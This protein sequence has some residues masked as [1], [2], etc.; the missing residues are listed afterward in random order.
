MLPQTPPSD[1]SLLALMDRPL[2]CPNGHPRPHGQGGPCPLCGSPPR[3]EEPTHARTAV[4]AGPEGGSTTV[5]TS[6]SRGLDLPGYEMLG[7]L[8]RGG[9]GTVHQ[10]RHLESQRLVAVKVLHEGLSDD[11]EHRARFRAEARALLR[12]EHPGIVRCLEAGEQAG[13]PY[14]VLELMTGGSLQERLA[15]R[16]FSPREAA[17]LVA[18]LALAVQAA[19]AAGIIHRDLKPGNVLMDGE[20][21][22]KVSDFGLAKH[23]EGS[24]LHTM[25]GAIM[26]TPAYMA[27]EQAAGRMSLIGPATDVYA[28]GAILYTLL[29]GQAPFSGESK[30]HLLERVRTE[31]PAPPTRLRP[32]VPRDLETICLK[33]LHKAPEGRYASAQA[34][35]DDL[36]RWLENRPILARRVGLAE[37]AAKWRQR[38]PV[39]A[40]LLVVASLASLAGGLGALWYWNAYLRVTVRHYRGFTL[41]KDGPVGIQALTAAEARGLSRS[42]RLSTR[43]GRA[44][45][46]ESV[47]ALGEL[48]EAS[49]GPLLHRAQGEENYP[50]R[51]RPCQY[52]YRRGPGGDLT[53]E[54]ARDQRGNVLW[55]LQ[56]TTPETA[57]YVNAR[58][59]ATARTGSGAAFVRFVWGQSG[60]ADEVHYLGHG[61]RPHPNDSGIYGLRYTRDE[62]GRVA[63]VVNLGRDGRPALD[64]D[65]LS[66]GEERE[67][68]GRGRLVRDW[69]LDRE[70]RRSRGANWVCG[71]EYK[72][73]EAGNCV[74]RRYFDE[75]GRPCLHRDG[76]HGWRSTYDERGYALSRSYFGLDGKPAVISQGMARVD[77]EPDAEGNVLVTRYFGADGAPCLHRDG[78]HLLRRKFDERGVL[79]EGAYYGV[80]GEPVIARGQ[81]RWV[82]TV[83]D[84]GRE[85]ETRYYGPDGNPALH[86]D[87]NHVVRRKYDDRGNVTEFSFFGVNQRPIL[88]KGGFAVRRIRYDEE[89]RQVEERCFGRDGEPC[90]HKEGYHGYTAK[91]DERGYRSERSYFGVDD[92]RVYHKAGVA[93]ARF[94]HD[95]QGREIEARYFGANNEPCLH[96]EGNH[97]IR[98]RYDGRGNLIQQEFLGLKDELVYVPAKGFARSL[99]EYDA[100]GLQRRQ[101]L[102]GPDG[103]PCLH[104]DGNAGVVH[105][106]N[107][108]GHVAEYTYL[109]LDG[110]PAPLPLG[111]TRIAT[112][113]TATG[114]VVEKRYL[115]A[116]GQPVVT[117]DGYSR[118]T[119]AYDLRGNETERACFGIDN[120]PCLFQGKFARIRYLHDAQDNRVEQ[121]LFGKDGTPASVDGHHLLRMKYDA[122]GNMIEQAYFDT[123]GKPCRHTDGN[124]ALR[125]TYDERDRVARLDYLGTNGKPVAWRGQMASSLRSY[126][127]RD[128]LT[129]L[130]FLGV[131]G[132]PTLV[133]G[134]HKRTTRYDPQD[135]PLVVTRH[136]VDGRPFAET[137]H[138]TEGPIEEVAFDKDGRALPMEVR[139][140]RVEAGGAAARLGVHAGD[141]LLTYDGNPVRSSFLFVRARKTA[142]PG[143]KPAPLVL[144]RGEEKLTVTVP[145]G[146]LGIEMANAPAR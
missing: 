29:T 130:R 18:E 11:E 71:T 40:T 108:R 32:D 115:D 7:R 89:G 136:G 140:R 125:F 45:R 25:S 26:G 74:E 133:N 22:P 75:A 88:V 4:Y 38:H 56:F 69:E 123:A 47:N 10:A 54:T 41:S 80:K 42:I 81:H 103:K 145:P 82:S 122:R 109:G 128:N 86:S 2:H 61:G 3:E 6:D 113:Y 15:E 52:D 50:D 129:E 28:L 98:R 53:H 119:I 78:N 138:D 87:G 120:R 9:M 31:E 64:R 55:V 46:V 1:T 62:L 68:D 117:R 107:E 124:H 93:R 102:F 77:S 135:R 97:A 51:L 112:A 16:A 137:R 19:H 34:L 13:R 36:R 91:F 39:L 27:P 23:L 92:G 70:G 43:A 144:R 44:E 142:V 65:T 90:L 49:S 57:F 110:E 17:G 84:H 104:P 94:L 66:A 105:T 60:L 20:G 95:D 83:D 99:A 21:R 100:R 101:L 121:R 127:A 106:L 96:K 111:V 116:K 126:D 118:I 85:T 37:R 12:L 72:Y 5:A 76:N 35:A 33:C 139:V 132:K 59:V 73:D 114:K 143:S 67:Y 141:V 8:G 131:S 30:V 79:V 14:F 24:T 146:P 63:R 134:V 58:G 48:A